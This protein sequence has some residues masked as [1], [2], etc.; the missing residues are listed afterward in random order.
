MTDCLVT[1]EHTHTGSNKNTLCVYFLPPLLVS[2]TFV[3]IFPLL[4]AKKEE[5]SIILFVLRESRKARERSVTAE[6]GK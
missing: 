3:T 6:E 1:A 2:K 5:K 4:S